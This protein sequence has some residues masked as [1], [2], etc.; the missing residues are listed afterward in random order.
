MES[1]NKKESKFELRSEKVRSIVGQIPSVLIRYGITVFFIILG[2]L[3]VIAYF[4][5]YKQI[6]SGRAIFNKTDDVA[7]DSIDIQI[8][9]IFEGKISGNMNGQ[10]I[11]IKS[12][13]NEFEGK[14]INISPVIDRQGKQKAVCRFKKS[15]TESVEDQTV[16][17]NIIRSS[18]SIFTRIFKNS[19]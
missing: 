4:M 6:Y 5:P 14:V 16:D 8:L 11:R 9:L 17:F 13:Y 15:E 18:G 2:C 3:F 1:D 19:I 7:S 10:K 12:Y